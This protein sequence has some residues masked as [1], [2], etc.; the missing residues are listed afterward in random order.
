MGGLFG[1]AEICLATYCVLAAPS[2][3]CLVV[4]S[5]SGNAYVGSQVPQRDEEFH[6][7]HVVPKYMFDVSSVTEMMLMFCRSLW[8]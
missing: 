2:C 3:G 7:I 6:Q 1:T 8:T 4:M 5:P